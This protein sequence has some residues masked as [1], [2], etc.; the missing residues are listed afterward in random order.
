MLKTVYM[1]VKKYFLLDFNLQRK[2]SI[3]DKAKL[4]ANF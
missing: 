1:S 2:I 3:L 4:K